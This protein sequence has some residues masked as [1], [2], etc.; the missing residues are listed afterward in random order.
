MF[1]T[2]NNYIK[3]LDTIQFQGLFNIG[4]AKLKAEIMVVNIVKQMNKEFD[5]IQV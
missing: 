5:L 1:I 2:Y 4:I 3:Y